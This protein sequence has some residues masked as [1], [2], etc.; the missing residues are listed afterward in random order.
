MNMTKKRLFGSIMIAIGIILA[1]CG[2]A[3]EQK[4]TIIFADEGWDSVRF[5]NEVAGIILD[6]GY[7]Y[8]M[9]QTTG[10]SAAVWQGLIDGD[11]DV[12][13][14]GWTQNLGEIYTNAI[15]S[16]EVEEIAVN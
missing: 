9:E 1:G 3:E 2:G 14:E 6:A 7:G 5:H 16:G 12:H 10:S 13:M 8:S 15:D 4:E 11:I